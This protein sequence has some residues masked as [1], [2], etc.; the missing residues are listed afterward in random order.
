MRTVVYCAVAGLS[1][2]ACYRSVCEVHVKKLIIADTMCVPGNLYRYLVAFVLLSGGGIRSLSHTY[3]TGVPVACKVRTIP[4][5]VE[6][7]CQPGAPS[8]LKHKCMNGM[9]NDYSHLAA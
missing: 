5:V 1:F 4:C 9:H 6:P 2:G 3:Q 7:K 8:K